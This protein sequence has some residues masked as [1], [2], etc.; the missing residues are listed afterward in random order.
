MFLKTISNEFLWGTA[1]LINAHNL[2]G[3][4]II[5]RDGAIGEIDDFYFDDERWAVRYLV[6]NTG[7]WLFRREVLL[8]PI[9]IKKVDETNNQVLVNLTRD[10]VKDCPD[11]D[12]QKPVSRQH[13]TAFMDY[14]G[15]PYY[16][17]GPY[18]WGD[19]AFPATLT[20]PPAVESQ[21]AAAATARM[22]ESEETYDEHLRSVNEVR[23]YHI[24]AADAEI[25]HV[26]DFI[27]DDR[28]WAIR[29]IIIKTGGW[30]SGRKILIPPQSI[31]RISWTEST[32]SVN[33]TRDQ[34]AENSHE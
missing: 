18:L 3:A 9:S 6:V 21:M 34:I 10:Q 5:A 32:M 1:M 19:A 12:T 7:A 23:G 4:A 26:D 24:G 13:E 31:E 8:S 30:L 28:D 29:S 14:Y 15:Y 16:W 27:I 20:M 22:R 17:G 2:K 11:I 33:L 25:G